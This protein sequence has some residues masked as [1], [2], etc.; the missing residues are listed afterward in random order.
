MRAG[1]VGQADLIFTDGDAAKAP[2]MTEAR[3]TKTYD[4]TFKVYYVHWADALR[5]AMV[6]C[7]GHGIRD[8]V[9]GLNLHR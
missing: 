4:L 9:N 2:E 6:C 7:E 1:E 8:W 3:Q 5:C